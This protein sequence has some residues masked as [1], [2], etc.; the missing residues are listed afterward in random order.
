MFPVGL[1]ADV[2]GGVVQVDTTGDGG[3]QALLKV[4]GIVEAAAAVAD[5]VLLLFRRLD[6]ALRGLSDHDVDELPVL[7]AVAEALI[8][9]GVAADAGNGICRVFDL[10]LFE[11]CVLF[12]LDGFSRMGEDSSWHGPMCAEAG[13]RSPAAGARRTDGTVCQRFSEASKKFKIA[14]PSYLDLFWGV[15]PFIPHCLLHGVTK[16]HYC[17]HLERRADGEL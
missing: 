3:V 1:A 11:G 8:G 15:L 17:L 12:G 13:A 2:D 5:P 7:G 14:M 4:N 16:G 10:S 9:R 6:Q